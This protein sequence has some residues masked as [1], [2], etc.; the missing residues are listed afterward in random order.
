VVDEP[1]GGL[2]FFM[3]AQQ[4]HLHVHRRPHCLTP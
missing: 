4:L 3:R 2:G 1:R